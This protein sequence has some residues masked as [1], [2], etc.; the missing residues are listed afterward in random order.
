MNPVRRILA[1]FPK[2]H[3]NIIFPFTPNSFEWSLPLRNSNQNYVCISHLSH[4]CLLD[5]PSE[6]YQLWSSSLCSLLQP[7]AT[8]FL[9]STLFSN[10]PRL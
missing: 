6:A 10:A 9:L 1:Y 8:V 4:A 2:T 5:H 7:P 3:S